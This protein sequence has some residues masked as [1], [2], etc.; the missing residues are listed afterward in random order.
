MKAIDF[1]VTKE[2]LKED[3][4]EIYGR[5]Y[6][7]ANKEDLLFEELQGGN[8]NIICLVA[9]RN[10]E[11]KWVIF[12]HFNMKQTNEM[13]FEATNGDDQTD[14][15]KEYHSIFKILSDRQGEIRVMNE[16]SKHKLCQKGKSFFQATRSCFKVEPL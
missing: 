4:L 2:N 11:D 16:L 7:N 1:T 8:I 5:L 10:G 15:N 9:N 14:A 12:R 3:T 13:S 6:E